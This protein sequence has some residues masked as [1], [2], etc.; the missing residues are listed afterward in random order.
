V[1]SL[2]IQLA[3]LYAQIGAHKR[4]TGVIGPRKFIQRLKTE[5]VLFSGF[6]QQDA[7]EFLIYLLNAISENMERDAR[8]EQKED[9][10]DPIKTLVHE[11]FEGV[12]TNE[13]KCMMCE[14]IT[15][16]DESFMDLSVDVEQNSSLTACL[17][18]FSRIETLSRQNK[19]WCEQCHSLQEAQ[20]RLRIKSPP[21][22]LVVQLK[23]FKFLEEIERYTKLNYRVAF[24]LDLKQS[25]VHYRL[26]AV[27]I[28][29]G[30]GPNQG[31][32][33]AVVR[34][35]AHWLL[36]DDE[37]VIDATAF[38]CAPILESLGD[39]RPVDIPVLTPGT[40]ARD[41]AKGGLLDSVRDDYLRSNSPQKNS[42]S[43]I[44]RSGSLLASK[45]N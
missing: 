9:S 15:S 28:H 19:F 39:Q 11:Y 14:T 26:G 22:V 38:N 43:E 42:Q 40:R 16:K 35:A 1:D 23:R 10:K 36:F 8:K 34:T 33:I 12:L 44:S 6:N 7:H 24:P 18:N 31:H 20:K 17:N 32:Y 29:L 13:T 3:Q 45:A 27:I 37:H 30:A 41:P 4:R 2:L 25:G 21:R 5:N